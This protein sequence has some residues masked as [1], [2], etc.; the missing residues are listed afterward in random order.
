MDRDLLGAHSHCIRNLVELNESAKAGC[1]YCLETYPASDVW[2]YIKELTED[3]E[4]TTAMC[5]K[6]GIDAVIGDKS[7]Y[8]VL[9][10]LFL[11]RMHGHWFASAKPVD[12]D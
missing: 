4:H 7:G 8:P 10:P 5:P 6:C 9:D 11:K 3:K 2:E 1:F 12:R